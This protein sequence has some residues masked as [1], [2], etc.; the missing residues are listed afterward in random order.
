[1]TLLVEEIY[2]IHLV[3]RVACFKSACLLL[4]FFA[5]SFYLL[6]MNKTDD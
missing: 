2:M 3:R 6:L 4:F 5:R 1:V